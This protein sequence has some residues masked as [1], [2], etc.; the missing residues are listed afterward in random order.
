[1]SS[2]SQNQNP[3]VSDVFIWEV[4]IIRKKN[5]DEQAI[6]TLSIFLPFGREG[7]TE[8]IFLKKER[9]DAT[10]IIFLLFFVND[11]QSGFRQGMTD[12]SQTF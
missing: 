12:N 8:E 9:I 2:Q 11:L 1:M 6:H 5:C 4:G 7:K 3:R 10:A